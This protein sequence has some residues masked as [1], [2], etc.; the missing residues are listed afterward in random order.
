MNVQGVQV[1][2][3]SYSARILAALDELQSAGVLRRIWERDHTVWRSDPTEIT[4]RL[5]WLNVASEMTGNIG[6]IEDFVREVR[7]EG[8]THALLLGM[9]G[10]SLAP[11]VFRKTFGVAAGMLDLAVLDS[12]DPAAV[13]SCAEGFN[14]D[15]TLF[16][17]S[18]KSGGT[19]ETFSFFKYFYNRLLERHSAEEVGRHFVAITDPGSGL[20]DTATRYRF[21]KVFLNNPDIGGRYSALS[22][23]GLAPAG[24]V[25]I[26]LKRLL[27]RAQ[28]Q[29]ALC[30]PAVPATENPAA[31]LGVVMGE[32]A[33]AGRDK[34]TLVSSPSLV[35]FGAWVEQLVAESTG[36]EGKGIVPVVG[37]APAAPA[38][39]G[40]DRLFVYLKLGDD[41]TYD[42][43]VDALERAGHP[44]VRM[45]LEDPFDLG[46]QFFLWELA[47]AVTGHCLE[48]QPFDQP[49]VESAKVLARQMVAAYREKGALPVQNAAL[50]DHDV[51]VYGK[52]SAETLS[53]AVVSFLSGAR[54][55]DYIAIQAYVP[56][57]PDVN[58]VLSALRLSLLERSRLAVTLGYGPRFL[59]STGQL[60]KGD[61][62]NSFFIQI[63]A[64]HPRDIPVPDEA[65]A[66]ASSMTFGVLI[67]SQALGDA[68]ALQDNQRRVLRLHLLGDVITGITQIVQSI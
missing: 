54:T 47:T 48:I 32:M 12:T 51:A 62:G 66:A 55:G 3:G 57:T 31:V 41:A 64:E 40:A 65:G 11:E 39:Y 38:V 63:T 6:E 60:H 7:A 8:F 43:G 10:S 18:T 53:Q 30:G 28:A 15:R 27:D 45:H 20:L 16:I 14:L 17:V 13:L 2:A 33:K 36:K 5:G 42:K 19:V 29:M 56:P 44:V 61:A 52:V 50:V 49:D 34:V 37:E 68:Q 26:D 35:S 67:D 21:R 24:M 58:A 9:G 22:C 59:H 25:G 23:F 1:S 4:N 46:G